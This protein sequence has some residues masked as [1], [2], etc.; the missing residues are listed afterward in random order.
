MTFGMGFRRP[1]ACCRCSQA[2]FPKGEEGKKKMKQKKNDW[3]LVGPRHGIN[4]RCGRVTRT[5]G[6]CE[7]AVTPNVSYAQPTTRQYAKVLTLARGITVL[8]R[9]LILSSTRWHA[10]ARIFCEHFLQLAT[11]RLPMLVAAS[12]ARAAPLQYGARTETS[13]AIWACGIVPKATTIASHMPNVTI[14]LGRHLRR[15][16]TTRCCDGPN[17]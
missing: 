5:Y 6:V 15:A 14:L 13:P 1:C 11:P 9:Q 17:L 10:L 4:L 16:S 2:N 7:F 8:H 12:A 3:P